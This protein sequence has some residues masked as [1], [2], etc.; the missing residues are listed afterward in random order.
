MGQLLRKR[1]LTYEIIE[2]PL[3]KENT[4]KKKNNTHMIKDKNLNT[5]NFMSSIFFYHRKVSLLF[6]FFSIKFVGS[7]CFLKQGN[8]IGDSFPRKDYL[9]SV[10][11]KNKKTLNGTKNILFRYFWAAI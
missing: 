10:S 8:P 4:S 1:Y 2:S 6:F 11:S 3:K 5:T 7:T 9:C